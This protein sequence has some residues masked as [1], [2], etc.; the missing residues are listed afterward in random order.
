MNQ[1]GVARIQVEIQEG[2]KGD[3]KREGSI[4]KVQASL[5]AFRGMGVW[6]QADRNYKGPGAELSA[7]APLR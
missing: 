4:W 7:A 3:P 1:S 5:G 2:Q 6:C